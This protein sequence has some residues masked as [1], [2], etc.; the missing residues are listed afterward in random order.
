MVYLE[1]LSCSNSKLH[2]REYAHNRVKVYMYGYIIQWYKKSMGTTMNVIV[3][4]RK[5][6]NL[7]YR[8]APV[9]K[10]IK[11]KEWHSK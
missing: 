2:P 3:V 6:V 10:N 11:R 7:E 5:M 4:I 8:A 1:L 9:M